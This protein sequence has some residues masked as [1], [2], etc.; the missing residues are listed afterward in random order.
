MAHGT[1]ISGVNKDVTAGFT[2]IN[3]VNKKVKKGLTLVN[4]VQKDIN[5]L[6]GEPVGNLAVGASVY[7]HVD[8]V[9]KEFIVV[10]QGIPS[11]LY[12]DS[13]DGAWLLMKDIYESRQWN[14]SDS[15]SYKE[16]SIHTYLNGTFLNLFDVGVKAQIKT[17]KIPYYNGKG[18]SGSVSSGS[19]GLSA[20]IFLLSACEVGFDT[21]DNIPVDGAALSYFTGAGDNNSNRIAYMGGNATQWH[22]RSP[23]K[24]AS[25]YVWFASSIGSLGLFGYPT[26]RK[27][28]R[29]ALILPQDAVVNENFQIIT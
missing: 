26:G 16:S 18:G 9:V 22:L 23:N 6:S 1:R 19:G 7:T 13:C 24:N 4:G 27:G 10:H 20:Q 28:I 12:D 25:S 15:N 17:A 2:R 3:G 8:G 29:P 5:F 11:G 14:S 21:Q